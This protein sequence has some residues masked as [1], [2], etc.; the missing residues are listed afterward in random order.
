L[1]ILNVVEQLSSPGINVMLFSDHGMVERI[2]GPT[3]DRSGLINIL[4]YVNASDWDRILASVQIW[5]KVGKL[6]SVHVISS[7]ACD[8]IAH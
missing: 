1:R 2:G 8:G 7:K 6:D 4:D 5:P 3:D